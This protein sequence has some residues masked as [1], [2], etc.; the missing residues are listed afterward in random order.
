MRNIRVALAAALCA[1]FGGVA[2]A[3]S[4]PIIV[5]PSAVH[6][7]AGTGME[8]GTYSAVLLGNPAKPGLYVVRLKAPAGT[9]F[10][11][12]YHNE[13]ENVTVIS[14]TLWVGLGDKMDKSKM[15]PLNAGTFVSVPARLHH[16]AMA[17]TDTVIQIEGMGPETMMAVGK[18]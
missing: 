11:P 8:K 18:M 5:S 3:A 13:T 14:G 1:A 15:R 7:V 4:A 17:K 16:Y 2:L 10:G 6:W 9:V 12:H